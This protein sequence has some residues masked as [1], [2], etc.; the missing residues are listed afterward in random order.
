MRF[1]G[2]THILHKHTLYI[3]DDSKHVEST[4]GADSK[5]RR[6]VHTNI[7]IQCDFL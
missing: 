5:V 2:Q 4:A 7:Y 3:Q 6:K 1:S